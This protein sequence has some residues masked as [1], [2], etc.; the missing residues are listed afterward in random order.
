M[1]AASGSS[2]VKRRRQERCRTYPTSRFSTVKMSRRPPQ[3]SMA[4][5][6]LCCNITNAGNSRFTVNGQSITTSPCLLRFGQECGS[7]NGS[8]RWLV[9]PVCPGVNMVSSR[10]HETLMKLRCV[11]AGHCE[12]SWSSV[13]GGSKSSVRAACRAMRKVP[14]WSAMR[15]WSSALG[16]TS[17]TARSSGSPGKFEHFMKSLPTSGGGEADVD[18]IRG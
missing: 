9:Q 7:R 10:E 17:N 14:R 6:H 16:R 18:W 13:C 11:D 3:I 5:I 1:P 2:A 8:Y 15:P 12:G 4:V